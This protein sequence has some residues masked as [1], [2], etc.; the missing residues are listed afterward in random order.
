MICP[1]CQTKDTKVV[2]SRVLGNCVRRRRECTKCDYRFSTY[3]N[4]EPINLKVIKRD[5]LIE[6]FNRNKIQ[7]GLEK[8][9]NKRPFLQKDIDELT[10][11]IEHTIYKTY[12]KKVKSTQ[13]GKLIL[14]KLSEIDKIAYLR[15]ASV[16]KNFRSVK[17]FSKEIKKINSR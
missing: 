7:K 11:E 10:C 17:T 6:E 16:Y 13:I 15:F 14:E 5:G 9:L 12:K 3:E 1:K 4:P 8:S 2:D